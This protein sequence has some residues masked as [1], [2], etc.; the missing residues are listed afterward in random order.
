MVKRTWK[1]VVWA[2]CLVACVARPVGED[3][4]GQ[5]FDSR[6]ASCAAYVGEYVA[7][8]DDVQGGQ[9]FTSSVVIEE[10]SGVCTITSNAIP[11]HDFNAM[12]RF[13]TPVAARQRRSTGVK[14]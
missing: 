6:E 14:S 11:N 9:S 8:V 10:S 7:S 4:G 1:I 5:V 3:I 2:T 13:A 12:G